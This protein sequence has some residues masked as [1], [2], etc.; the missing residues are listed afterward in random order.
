[1]RLYYQL[2]FDNIG[3]QEVCLFHPPR[4]APPELLRQ[5]RRLHIQH[6]PSY[7]PELNSDE[8]VWSPAKRALA[9]SCPNDGE[10]LVE[11]VI[12]SINGIPI[13]T[14]KLRGCIRQSG[15]PS[16]LRLDYSTPLFMQPAINKQE[17][18]HDN[19]ETLKPVHPKP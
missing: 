9:N 5:H 8:G 11:D 17:R 6:F 12:P 1:M 4:K 16:F 19:I 2:Y 3:Q 18:K 14:R 10:E 13:S 7:A 15:P